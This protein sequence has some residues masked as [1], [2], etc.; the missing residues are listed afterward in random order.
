MFRC[1]WCCYACVT[2]FNILIHHESY[3]FFSHHHHSLLIEFSHCL[4]F[5]LERHCNICLKL[6][7]FLLNFFLFLFRFLLFFLNFSQCCCSNNSDTNICWSKTSNI[8]WSITGIQYTTVINL[9]N[10]FYYNLLIM[11]RC[12]CKDFDHWEILGR[13]GFCW[14]CW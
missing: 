9:F 10:F 11:W 5:F 8:I 14:W 1:E 4:Q 12:S 2:N 7:H 13:K 6:F 3:I